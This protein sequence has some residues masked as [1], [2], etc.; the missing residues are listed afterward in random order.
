VCVQ[1]GGGNTNWLGV[2]GHT[3]VTAARSDGVRVGE[4]PTVQVGELQLPRGATVF[5]PACTV[6]TSLGPG[7][8]LGLS[9][10]QWIE[11]V[12]LGWGKVYLPT[13]DT[14]VHDEL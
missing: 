7:H 14:E 9:H 2:R 13:G 6:D 5:L 3:T 4:L 12:A 10:T 1:L 11:L 8:M